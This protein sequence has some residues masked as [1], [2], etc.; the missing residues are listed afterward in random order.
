M[1]GELLGRGLG[2]GQAG[3]DLGRNLDRVAPVVEVDLALAAGHRQIHFGKKL[4]VEQCAV[5]HAGGV[6]DLVHQAQA[7]KTHAAAGIHLAGDLKRV[8]DLRDVVLEPAPAETLELHV[9]EAHV[10][11][12]VVNEQL[13]VGDE[14][15]ELVHDVRKDGTVL[16][17]L[18]RD[19]VNG[20]RL[21]GNVALGI[22]VDLQI[23][24]GI[25]RDLAAVEPH[26]ADLENT[27]ALV[28]IKTRR[29]RIER[30]LRLV[31]ARVAL[32]MRLGRHEDLLAGTSLF[33]GVLREVDPLVFILGGGGHL[34]VSHVSVQVT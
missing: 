11:L 22:N 13:R 7:V 12:R 16:H 2:H 6:V 26:A 32:L 10:E 4:A 19:A 9:D 8:R 20:R 33:R 34:R 5:E 23:V 1:L 27:V 18:V 29:F 17:L 28:G 14:V 25:K 30:D 31:E 3:D 24:V 21:L 15:E